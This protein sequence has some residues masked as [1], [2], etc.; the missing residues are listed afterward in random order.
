LRDLAF[1]KIFRQ[2]AEGKKQRAIR[3]DERGDAPRENSKG[4]A[5]GSPATGVGASA[6]VMSSIERFFSRLSLGPK[7]AI[8][9]V[10]QHRE[11]FDE[12]WLR[13]IAERLDGTRFSEPKDGAE[14]EGGTVY[15]CAADTITAIRGRRFAVRPARQAPGERPTLDSFLMSL[16]EERTEG[17]MGVVLAGTDGV[18]VMITIIDVTVIARAE[19][20]QHL[21][22]AELQHRVRNTLGVVRSIARR[23]AETSTSVED[24]ASHLDGRLNAFARTQA[25]VT[26]DPEGGVDLEYLVVEE[27]LGYNAREGEQLRV[28]GPPVRFQPKAAETFAL[29]IHELATNA[30]KYGALSQ[31]SG[32]VDVSWCVDDARDPTR[33]IFDWQERG[34][35][36]VAPP[37][38]KGFGTELL[39]RTMAFELKA[40][41]TL[42]FDASGFR[43][44]IAIPLTRR[45]VHTPA[46]GA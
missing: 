34:G 22:L 35:P 8:V 28:S 11:A 32:R 20:R 2:I 27:L 7:R 37:R 31:P 24:Y 3:M 10:L 25:M 13:G 1:A 46:V 16:T 14:I 33:L 17:S 23:S 6:S 29:A 4:E 40:E 26:R 19:E 43:C 9:I 5:K 39:E 44:I 36:D 45:V 38:R 30:I 41:S 12:N 42:T 21:L 18:G 15:L